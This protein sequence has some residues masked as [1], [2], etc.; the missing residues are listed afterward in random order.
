M[1]DGVLAVFTHN[2]HFLSLCRMAPNIA[3][4]RAF[5]FSYIAADNRLVGAMCLL[6]ANLLGKA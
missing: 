3:L 6:C 4:Y 5:F 1:R 2:R